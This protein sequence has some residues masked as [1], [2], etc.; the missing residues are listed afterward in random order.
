MKNLKKYFRDFHL[1]ITGTDQ[2]LAWRGQGVGFKSSHST[3]VWNV[4]VGLILAKS[5][6]EDYKC[7]AP[8]AGNKRSKLRYAILFYVIKIIIMQNITA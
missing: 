8:L 5:Y 3:D 2:I 1:H 7:T 4:S 6:S